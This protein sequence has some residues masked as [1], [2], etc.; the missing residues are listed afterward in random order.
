MHSVLFAS[1]YFRSTTTSSLV[2]AGLLCNQWHHHQYNGG[3]FKPSQIACVEPFTFSASQSCQNLHIPTVLSIYLPYCLLILFWSCV[4]QK[5]NRII[6]C[7]VY[8]AYLAITD[9]LTVI[10]GAYYWFVSGVVRNYEFWECKIT[11]WF[12]MW[13]T[14][15]GEIGFFTWFFFFFFC[16]SFLFT[17]LRPLQCCHIWEWW[18]FKLGWKGVCVSTV[19]G[20]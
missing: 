9:T 16:I 19:Y 20:T 18:M 15:S 5:H 6:S 1:Y 10:F 17:C 4:F 2:C 13:F 12:V 14:T 11:A 3:L 8:M 7:C